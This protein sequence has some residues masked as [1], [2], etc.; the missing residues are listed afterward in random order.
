M[1]KSHNYR[2]GRHLA[3]IQKMEE[4]CNKHFAKTLLLFFKAI[5]IYCKVDVT[6]RKLA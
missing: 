5:Q 4:I 6:R 3:P 1:K 2:A